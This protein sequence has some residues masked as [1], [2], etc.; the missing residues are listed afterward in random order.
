[1]FN[2]EKAMVTPNES[3]AI[4]VYD[5]IQKAEHAID[6]LRQAG[7]RSEE[8]GIIGHVA[9]EQVPTPAKMHAPEE[10]A[11]TAVLRGGIIG[12]IGGAF[13]ILVVPGLGEVAGVGRWFDVVG[14][15]TL[16]ACVTG[17]LLAFASFLFWKPRTRFYA[18]QLGKGNFI[19]TVTNPTRSDEAVSV[20]RRQ[21]THVDRGEAAP[22]SS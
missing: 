4:G 10:N 7:F 15:A 5:D 8:I 22:M 17:V 12:A 3:S 18:A 13:V 6:E 20:L 16:G 11:M 19:V 14:G 21:S 2:K 1:M 9:D